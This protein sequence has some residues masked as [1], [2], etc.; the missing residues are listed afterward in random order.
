MA[1]RVIITDQ[2]DRFVGGH[3]RA[4]FICQIFAGALQGAFIPSFCENIH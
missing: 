1:S 3:N 4:E 2:A